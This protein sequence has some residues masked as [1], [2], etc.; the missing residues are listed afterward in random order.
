MRTKSSLRLVL[1]LILFSFAMVAPLRS[2]AH[3]Q[4]QSSSSQNPAGPPG[5]AEELAKET[6]EAAGEEEENANLK[7][8]AMVKNLAK[9]T[10]MSVHEAH[11]VALG[12]NFALIVFLV[13]WFGRKSV[14]LALRNRTD[15]IR[16]ALDDA[17]AAS[18]EANLRL[19]AIEARLKKLDSEISQMQATAEMEAAGEEERIQKAAEEDMRKVVLAAEQEIAA[20][21]KQARRELTVLTA[22]LAITLAQQQ[23]QVD[24]DTDQALVRNFA[25]QL[26]K[27]GGKDTQ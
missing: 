15:S 2:V 4:E 3:A 9:V 25:G 26:S 6:R 22:D 8:S 14:P 1:T 23:I 17:R 7:H 27:N 24:S 10:G 16:R 20:A 19:S 21:A 11:M 12:F 18:Q 5:P 13:Y